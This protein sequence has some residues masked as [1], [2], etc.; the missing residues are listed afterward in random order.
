MTYGVDIH[1]ELHASKYVLKRF[2]IRNNKILR[3]IE[4][5]LFEISDSPIRKH[6]TDAFRIT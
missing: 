3:S 5:L 4:T 2:K 6:G 1:S